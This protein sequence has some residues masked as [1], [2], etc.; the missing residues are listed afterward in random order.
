MRNDE[1][2]PLLSPRRVLFIVGVH[3]SVSAAHVVDYSELQVTSGLKGGD[4]LTSL[5]PPAT[6]RRA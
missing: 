6:K 1:G 4:L 2:G 3:L 5:T